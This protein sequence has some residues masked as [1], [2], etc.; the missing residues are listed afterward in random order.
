MSHLHRSGDALHI[1]VLDSNA[2]ISFYEAATDSF[3]AGINSNQ[4]LFY[5]DAAMNRD[6]TRVATRGWAPY[7]TT[8]KT[9]PGF[10][11]LNTFANLDGAVAFDSA[12]D[13]LYGTSSYLNQVIA[14]DANTFAERFR[15]DIGGTFNGF[16]SGL[17]TASP[18]GAYVG[19]IIPNGFRVYAVPAVQIASAASVRMHGSNSYAVGLP[20]DGPR[21]VEPRGGGASGSHTRCFQLRSEPGQRRR[22]DR[23]RWRSEQQ[24]DRFGRCASVHYQPGQCR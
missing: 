22:R 9:A 18:N 16:D 13:T 7:T 3:S 2:R 23:Y 5:S 14:Y 19:L 11:L 6:G 12:G 4:G 8:L 17:L 15:F 20:L 21:A 24:D 10:V 1:Y